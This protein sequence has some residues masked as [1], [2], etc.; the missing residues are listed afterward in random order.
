MVKREVMNSE[1]DQIWQFVTILAI[2]RPFRLQIFG[3][4]LAKKNYK[5]FDVD[6]LGL[7]KLGYLLWRQIWR[8]LPKCWRIFCPNTWSLCEQSID[9]GSF[10]NALVFSYLSI[11][12]DS[13]PIVWD[14]SLYVSDI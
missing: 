4:K 7:E 3:P 14:F 10:I 6:I 1:C 9:K 11:W 13:K 2:F 8:F 12:I 5:S